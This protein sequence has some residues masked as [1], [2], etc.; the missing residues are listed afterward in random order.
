VIKQGQLSGGKA[1]RDGEHANMGGSNKLEAIMLECGTFNLTA[2]L[3]S[4]SL[5]PLPSESKVATGYVMTSSG[6]L[7][8][9]GK[10]Q[11]QS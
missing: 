2:F 11:D 3:M 10:W 5:R 7:A 4:R 9:A 8:M 6:P 1:V